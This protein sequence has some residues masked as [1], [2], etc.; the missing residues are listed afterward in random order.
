MDKIEQLKSW[1]SW[2]VPCWLVYYCAIRLAVY[3]TTGK[4]G[5]QI[6]PN[7]LFMDALKRYE[8]K[9]MPK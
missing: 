1:F 4:Y 2:K 5:K 3:A 6:T 7:L 8:E 9:Y